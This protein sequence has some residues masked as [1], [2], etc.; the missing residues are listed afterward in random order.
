MTFEDGIN[1]EGNGS[2]MHITIWPKCGRGVRW[3]FGGKNPLEARRS[4][5]SGL[6]YHDGSIWLGSHILISWPTLI[7]TFTLNKFH[8]AYMNGNHFV[9]HIHVDDRFVSHS[10][11]YFNVVRH[12]VRSS[13]PFAHRLMRGSLVGQGVVTGSE[14]DR[15][16]HD[17]SQKGS[18]PFSFI[19]VCMLFCYASL[20]SIHGLIFIY[21]HPNYWLLDYD[22]ADFFF[23]VQINKKNAKWRYF[24]INWWALKLGSLEGMKFD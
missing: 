5:A 6:A 14:A 10:L 9:K 22:L 24:I 18:L 1:F 7:F 17:S 3:D 21:T 12:C 15:V 11:A 16:M 13:H 4:W 20:S 2:I 23:R 8:C 19:H